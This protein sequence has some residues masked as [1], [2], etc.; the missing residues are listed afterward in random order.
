MDIDAETEFLLGIKTHIYGGQFVA[1]YS[2]DSGVTLQGFG[3]TPTEAKYSLLLRTLANAPRH[4]DRL[5]SRLIEDDEDL[6]V[7]VDFEI[8][9]DGSTSIIVKD[10]AGRTRTVGGPRTRKVSK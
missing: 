5:R 10:S 9:D 1:E 4:M 2:S 8:H 7:A 3:R 6:D